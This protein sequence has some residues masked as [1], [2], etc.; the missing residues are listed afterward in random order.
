MKK[1]VKKSKRKIEKNREVDLSQA[2]V[3]I[4][5]V[6]IPQYSRKE[7][8]HM[9][10]K[11]H[12][13]PIYLLF[14]ELVGIVGM[15]YFYLYTQRDWLY[16]HIQNRDIYFGRFA[17]IAIAMAVVLIIY[18]KLF[19]GYLVDMCTCQ[20]CA[21]ELLPVKNVVYCKN[22]ARIGKDA[23]WAEIRI[24]KEQYKRSLLIYKNVSKYWNCFPDEL[25]YTYDKND[26]YDGKGKYQ[27]EAVRFYYLKYSKLVVKVEV[28]G[29]ALKDERQNKK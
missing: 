23:A 4:P 27:F 13:R 28:V 18:L 25:S 1:K 14:L 5:P 3:T 24:K 11:H 12:I 22:Y 29:E 8:W 9:F 19:R 20:I 10:R 6:N 26:Y 16:W 21:T 15:I 2:N 17:V 7:I